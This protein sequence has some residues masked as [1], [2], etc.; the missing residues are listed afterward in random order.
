MSGGRV[1]SWDLPVVHA[2]D[3]VE[4]LPGFRPDQ[5]EW[6]GF[7][8]HRVGRGDQMEWTSI[9]AYPTST[10]HGFVRFAVTDREFTITDQQQRALTAGDVANALYVTFRP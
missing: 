1:R 5:V 2:L 9:Y 4:T 8:F 3:A 6:D 7:R 10:K